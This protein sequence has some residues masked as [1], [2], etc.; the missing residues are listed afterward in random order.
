MS[1]LRHIFFLASLLISIPVFADPIWIGCRACSEPQ[2]DYKVRTTP[3]FNI[4]EVS[5]YVIDDINNGFSVRKFTRFID[6]KSGGAMRV[7]EHVLDATDAVRI[8]QA[9]DLRSEWDAGKDLQ[10]PLSEG[11]ETYGA[12]DVLG[13]QTELL[14]VSD[15]IRSDSATRDM[16][17]RVLESANQGLLSYFF[18]RETNVSVRV[19]FPDGSIGVFEA[20]VL[21]LAGTVGADIRYVPV[22]G[23]FYSDDD[24]S[25]R[26]SLPVNAND[27]GTSGLVPR[28]YIGNF[29]GLLDSHAIGRTNNP[30]TLNCSQYIRTVRWNITGG[31]GANGTTQFITYQCGRF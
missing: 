4:D 7:F 6:F 22:P 16:F 1:L 10:I 2:L 27:L 11:R 8:L 23:T 28:N 18:E 9:N 29:E 3:P 12:T 20:V 24:D 17:V 26:I 13:N 5:F 21:L 14:R 30:F 31:P 19:R 25:D 15:V